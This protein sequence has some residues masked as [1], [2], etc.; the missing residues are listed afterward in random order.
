MNI[1]KK[2]FMIMILLSFIT[3]CTNSITDLSL[4]EKIDATN[5]SNLKL[6]EL[7]LKLG[8]GNIMMINQFVKGF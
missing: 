3:S 4:F 6:K 7:T 1:L 8:L 5:L 2:S